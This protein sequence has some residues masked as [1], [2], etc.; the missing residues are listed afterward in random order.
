MKSPGL[1][2]LYTFFRVR[3]GIDMIETILQHYG[4]RQA[5]EP[6]TISERKGDPDSVA[7]EASHPNPIDAAHRTYKTRVCVGDVFVRSEPDIN[8]PI[9]VSLVGIQEGTETIRD[10]TQVTIQF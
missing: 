2:L 8:E 7:L 10:E 1:V 4:C 3:E 5:T 9:C 6:G